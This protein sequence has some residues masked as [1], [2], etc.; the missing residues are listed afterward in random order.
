VIVVDTNILAYRFI[1]GARNEDADRL[2]EVEPK[3]AAPLLWRSELRN[4][5]CGYLRRG[6]ISRVL[7]EVLLNEAHLALTAGEHVVD[8]SLVFDLVQKSRCTSYD[9]EFVTL[10]LM[11]DVPLV[12][13]DSDL[14]KAFPAHCR[15]LTQ[16]LAS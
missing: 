3:W 2:A 6:Q 12:T 13:E 9:C 15:T 8:D 5:L 14:L 10:A 1:A 16:T 11:L 4:V 7:A